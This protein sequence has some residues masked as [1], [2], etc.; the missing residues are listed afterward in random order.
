MEGMEGK[1]SDGE[2]RMESADPPQMDLEVSVPT[3]HI[4]TA[5]YYFLTTGDSSSRSHDS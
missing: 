2:E 1:S 4:I 3:I 5:T